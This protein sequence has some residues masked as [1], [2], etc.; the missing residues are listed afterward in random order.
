MQ[1]FKYDLCATFPT[2]KVSCHNGKNCVKCFYMFVL[3]CL[4]FEILCTVAL[5]C[6]KKDMNDNKGGLCY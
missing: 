1:S 2:W 4:N 6:K 5:A 3:T